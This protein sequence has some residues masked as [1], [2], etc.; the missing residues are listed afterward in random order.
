MNLLALLAF[1][2]GA[3]IAVQAT[4]NAQLGVLLKSSMVSTSIA[5]FLSCLFSTVALVAFTKEYP[6]LG[7]VKAIP[8]YLWFGGSLLSAFAVGMFYYL[9][10]LMGIGTMM[11][12]ALSGQLIIAMISSHFGWFN[13]PVQAVSV[14][15][16]VGIIT[17]I[18]GLFLINWNSN[19]GH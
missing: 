16:T 13:L 9:I 4:M 8:W 15:K 5:F 3:A 19:Y 12:Y 6:D 17:L 10:P 1:S 11:S 18:I 14:Q 2:A 7:D